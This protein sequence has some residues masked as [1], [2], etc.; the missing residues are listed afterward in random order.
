MM[1][2]VIAGLGLV[3]EPITLM[4]I[5]LASVYGLF[6]G[7][8]P[9]L[10]ATMAMALMLP[11]LIFVPA[12]TALAAVIAMHA[13]AITSSDF[14]A[15]AL[16]IPGTPASAAYVDDA[17]AL[18]QKGRGFEAIGILVF[19]SA[20]GGIFGSAALIVGA[21]VLARFATNFTSFEYFWLALLGLSAAIVIS[22]GSMI[23]GLIS[24]FLGLAISTIGM[25]AS[26]GF[27]RFT[28]GISALLGGIDLVAVMVGMFGLSQV[29]RGLSTP[30]GEQQSGIQS[31]G[32]AKT[33]TRGP[34]API[35]RAFR[36]NIREMIR[37]SAIGS[38][39]GAMPGAGPDVAAYVSY[40][41]TKSAAKDQTDFGHG[42]IP[43]L[44]SCG[45]G[46]NA[47]L[48]AAWIPTLTLGIPGDAGTAMLLGLFLI[49]GV[50][51]GPQLLDTQAPLLY[52]VF[53]VFILANILLLPLGYIGMR[54]SARVM[55]IS[56]SVL[57]PIIVI[58]CIAGAFATSND[59]FGIIVMAMAGVLGYFMERYGF[60][61]A[62][63][64]LGL[65]LGPIIERTFVSS[66]I[67][68]GGNLIEFVSRPISAILA[69]LTLVF[70]LWPQIR[71]HFV[72]L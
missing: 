44:V 47:A 65:I 61:V 28:G 23:K 36:E 11:F 59:M 71:S 22:R 63:L 30:E 32:F 45:T 8:V 52:S 27:P 7:A 16:R 64:L 68:S 46:N 54:L 42:N 37:G 17:F 70:L 55:G 58:I 13:M 29:L 26:L 56:Q 2:D 10:T 20:I 18:T 33:M 21:P 43:A 41:A 3:V 24:T 5:I 9:G 57:L 50:Q 31:D 6:M 1:A 12:S 40:A 25:D 60:S 14:P 49:H 38:V 66:L 48:A 19:G 53:I 69:V 4:A 67:K 72:R 34:V 35:L 51:P 39:V 15:V 62:A